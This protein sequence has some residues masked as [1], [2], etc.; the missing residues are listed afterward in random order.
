MVTIEQMRAG[1]RVIVSEQT[2][3][4]G[5]SWGRIVPN[6]EEACVLILHYYGKRH[7]KRHCVLCKNIGR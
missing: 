3:R 5:T 7:A 6:I 1:F 4:A 2:G